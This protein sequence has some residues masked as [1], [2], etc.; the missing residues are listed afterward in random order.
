[1]T[2]TSTFAARLL[3]LALALASGAASAAPTLAINSVL[4]RYPW[5]N[6]ADIRYTVGGT[7]AADTAYYVSFYSVIDGVT[8]FAAEAVVDAA[9]TYTVKWRVPAG[10][11][12]QDCKMLG[13]I[14]SAGSLAGGSEYM[15]V[16]L[17]TG[18]VAYEKL[19]D[20]QHYSD[21][22]YNTETYKSEKM[23]FRRVPAGIYSMR[24]GQL[25]TGG[26][27][28]T[29]AKMTNDYY[30]GVFE[31]TAAQYTL[32]DN[33][34]ASVSI[35]GETL[36]PKVSVGWETV[37]GTLEV[38]STPSRGETL[39]STSPIY[40][41]NQTVNR[42]DVKFD[43]P[44]EAMWEV[45]ARAEAASTTAVDRK[46]W[47]FT[48]LTHNST[49]QMVT[50]AVSTNAIASLLRK[51]AWCCYNAGA[52]SLSEPWLYPENDTNEDDGYGHYS[53]DGRRVVGTKAAN[54][55][56]LYDVYG[57]VHEWCIDGTGDPQGLGDDG[58][59]WSLT[60]FATEDSA[61]APDRQ[62][63]RRRRGGGFHSGAINANSVD[64]GYHWGSNE[65]GSASEVTGFRL[66]AIVPLGE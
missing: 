58:L 16:N 56:G 29:T 47:F 15:V 24:D 8:N 33:K 1:M 20:T 35:T 18:A 21:V 55:W 13:K 4:Q 11:L 30:I 52:N 45:A 51:Y 23:A 49:V 54:P 2:K 48:N 59:N 22:R 14:A 19:L 57:N 34:N 46:T 39:G 66:S 36:L 62:Y 41:L 9:G 44:T 37:R 12:A 64:R 27:K 28:P 3:A 43:L 25:P 5:S 65:K 53:A 40:K 7:L 38:P 6:T 61:E 17:K 32:M 26:T 60:P 42:S 10:K 31:V 63:L 50:D